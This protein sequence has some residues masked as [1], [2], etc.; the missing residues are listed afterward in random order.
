MTVFMFM[1]RG[2]TCRHQKGQPGRF[3]DRECCRYSHEPTQGT[4]DDKAGQI[5]KLF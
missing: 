3:N 5:A 4:I 1:H 2:L